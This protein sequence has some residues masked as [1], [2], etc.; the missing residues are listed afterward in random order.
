MKQKLRMRLSMLPLHIGKADGQHVGN[1]RD[2]HLGN[3]ESMSAFVQERRA[4]QLANIIIHLMKF[5]F[6][7]AL[8]APRVICQ[9]GLYDARPHS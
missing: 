3:V 1:D 6:L 8:V 7:H 5:G 9:C 4:F 2:A